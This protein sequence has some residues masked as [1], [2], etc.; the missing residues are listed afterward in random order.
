MELMTRTIDPNNKFPGVSGI[1]LINACGL[2]PMWV[3]SVDEDQSIKDSVIAA[4]QF[5][6]Y[7]FEGE[8]LADGTYR[9]PGDPDLHPIVSWTR[10]DETVFMYQHAII[11]FITGDDVF[12][13]RMD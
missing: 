6:T 12:I 3:E 8:V 10:G 9:Y 11:A 7:K 2:I 4:Y 13:T 1:A 5:P